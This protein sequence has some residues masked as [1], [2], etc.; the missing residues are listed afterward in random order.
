MAAAAPGT[1]VAVGSDAQESSRTNVA[2]ILTTMYNNVKENAAAS[3]G[4]A[5]PWSE[6][7]ERSSF[8][9]FHGSTE[10][11]GRLRKNFAYFK[12]NYGIVGIATTAL[13]MFFNPWSVVVLAGL[14]LVWFYA[15][16]IRSGPFVFNGREISDR[17]K[18]LGLS[19][20]SLVV[21]FFLTSVGAV[22]FY[23]LGLSALVV[24]LHGV[25]KVPDDL[26]LDDV[27]ETQ[28]TGL[29]S[30]FTGA[31]TGPPLRPPSVVTAV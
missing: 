14:A 7:F 18:F 29:L 20:A 16:L 5:R 30:F 19:V 23:A 25:Y 6:V 22:L 17:E 11:M 3:L 12:V 26:F 15:Y 28:A 31:T 4:Q 27:P 21:V 2:S 9:K 13:V 1:V 10:A 8:A 24:G